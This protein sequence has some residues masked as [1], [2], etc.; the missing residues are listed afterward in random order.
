[1]AFLSNC[2]L[3]LHRFKFITS[4][5]VE[6]LAQK[7]AQRTDVQ[8]YLLF[9]PAAKPTGHRTVRVVVVVVGGLL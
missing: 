6:N 8:L 4:A 3:N 2:G 9:L 1:M 5:Y 7:N